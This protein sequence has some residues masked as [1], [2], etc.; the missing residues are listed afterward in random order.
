MSNKC[1]KFRVKIRAVAKKMAKNFRGYDTFLPHSVC[2][3]HLPLKPLDGMR[4]HLA[5]TLM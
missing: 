5:W 4:C 3:C 1:V 2:V